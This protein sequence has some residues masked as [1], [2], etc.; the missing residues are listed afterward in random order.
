MMDE[1]NING[2]PKDWKIVDVSSIGRIETGSTPSKQNV[3]YYANDFPFYKPTDLEAGYNVRI[4]RDN[5][6]KTGIKEARF[7]PENSI[8]VTC[9]GATIGKTGFI[10]K[11][12]ASNQQI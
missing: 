1:Q 10:R 2:L 8:L 4:A 11:E 6:S 9:I 7:L 5:L 12:G 3:D